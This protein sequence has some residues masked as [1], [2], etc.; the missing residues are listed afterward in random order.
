M[1]IQNGVLKVILGQDIPFVYPNHERTHM[2]YCHSE[3][4]HYWCIIVNI[5]NKKTQLM[6]QLRPYLDFVDYMHAHIILRKR[7]P[8]VFN[9]KFC[10]YH[11]V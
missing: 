11:K 3:C 5:S 4:K 6:L 8:N 10:K 9:L 2:C 7:D 1:V